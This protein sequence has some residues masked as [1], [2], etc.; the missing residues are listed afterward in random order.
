MRF[1]LK[2][3]TLFS[4]TESHGRDVPSTRKHSKGGGP[5]GPNSMSFG[6]DI[7]DGREKRNLVMEGVGGA[8]RRS[9]PAE[10]EM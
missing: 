9:E 4:R 8:G 2:F 10:R 6:R 3:Q 1:G 5:T 7:M